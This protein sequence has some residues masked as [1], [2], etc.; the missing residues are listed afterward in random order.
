MC[1]FIIINDY[2]ILIGS[3]NESNDKKEYEKPWRIISVWVIIQCPMY[4]I[5][6]QCKRS[7]KQARRVKLEG[8]DYVRFTLDL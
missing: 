1:V 5:L 3:R 6:T 2:I 4:I 7:K 8:K